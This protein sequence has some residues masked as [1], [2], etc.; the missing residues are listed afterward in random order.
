L[1]RATASRPRGDRSTRIKIIDPHHHLRDKTHNNYPW[2]R[3]QSPEAGPEGDITPIAR[4]YLLL[5]YRRTR[6][7]AAGTT[8]SRSAKSAGWNRS[9]TRT[10]SSLTR[11][12]TTTER[13]LAGH[14]EFPNTPGIRQIIN[15]HRDPIQN[16]V[17]RSAVMRDRVWLRHFESLERYDP[18]VRLAA[19]PDADGRRRRLTANHRPPPVKHAR[20]ER[21]SRR[22]S[23]ENGISHGLQ[24]RGRG[25]AERRRVC[26]CERVVTSFAVL[27]VQ[28]P[29]D[30]ERTT[31][32]MVR[33]L[34]L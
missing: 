25:R 30:H 20:P 8:P 10:A 21:P 18:F 12:S 32:A 5:D 22:S 11:R 24:V 28:A 2:Q 3:R 19:L 16:Y 33:P 15:W 4:L 14:R 29:S 9:P 13:V 34:V 17:P 7:I 1:P 31:R 26:E 27:T 6:L 23:R